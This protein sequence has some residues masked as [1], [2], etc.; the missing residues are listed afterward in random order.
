MAAEGG[1]RAAAEAEIRRLLELPDGGGIPA[2]RAAS[3]AA[4]LGDAPRAVELLE[5]SRAAGRMYDSWDHR[6]PVWRKIRGDSA[7]QAFIAPQG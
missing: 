6:S 7:Y 4:A 3:I 1:D 5:S 2:L